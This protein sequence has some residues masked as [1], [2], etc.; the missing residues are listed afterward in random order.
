[1]V[2]YYMQLCILAATTDNIAVNIEKAK[3]VL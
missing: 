3:R 2:F 1:M